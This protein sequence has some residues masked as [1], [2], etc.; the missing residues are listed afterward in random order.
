MV[1]Y[2]GWL[3][4][5]ILVPQMGNKVKV[6]V[7]FKYLN[8]SSPKDDFLLPQVDLLVD[9]NADHSTLSFMDGFFWV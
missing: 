1:E 3:A 6:C 8:K 2:L 9:N 4:N 5:V 7:D